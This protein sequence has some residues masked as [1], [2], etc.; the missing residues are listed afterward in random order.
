LEDLRQKMLAR[1]DEQAEK[2]RQAAKANEVHICSGK[3]WLMGVDDSAEEG[4][5]VCFV[6]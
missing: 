5:R 2:E 4:S 3:G 1:K 6:D